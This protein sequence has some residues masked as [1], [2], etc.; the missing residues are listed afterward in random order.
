MSIP[1]APFPVIVTEWEWHDIL[2]RANWA[3]NARSRRDLASRV[4]A[5]KALKAAA[6]AAAQEGT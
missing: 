4:A 2:T 6:R 5:Y 1:K 3:E